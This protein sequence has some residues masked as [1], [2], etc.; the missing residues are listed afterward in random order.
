MSPGQQ[1]ELARERFELQDYYGAIHLVQEMIDEGKAFADA[2]HLLGLAYEMA[3]QPEN[4][5]EAFDR[6]LSLNPRYVEAHLHRGIVLAHLGRDDEA[7]QAFS[8]ARESGGGE[9]GG[10]PAHHASKLANLHAELGEAYVEAGALTRAID[11]YQRALELGPAYHDLRYRLG[12]LLLDAGRSLE[13]REELEQVVA[14]GAQWVEARTAYGLACYLAG[15]AP[16]ARATWEAVQAERPD[17][18]KVRAYLSLLARATE[19]GAG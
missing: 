13:A 5:L 11:Q 2:H 19:L 16:T 14:A 8:A 9:R 12:R 3:D 17:D 15:D 6:A 1:L 4:A 18:P 10:V 7:A